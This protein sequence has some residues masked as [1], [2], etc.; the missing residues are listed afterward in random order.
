MFTHTICKVHS[1]AVFGHQRV[2]PGLGPFRHPATVELLQSTW[3]QQNRRTVNHTQPAALRREDPTGC[4][5]ARPPDSV[6]HNRPHQLTLAIRRWIHSVCQRG[7]RER[8]SHHASPWS[9][10]VNAPPPFASLQRRPKS[11]ALERGCRWTHLCC[12]NARLLTAASGIEQ[13]PAPVDSARWLVCRPR[14]VGH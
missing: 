10:A 1:L 11:S 12:R 9:Q 13:G 2:T 6:G 3:S 14:P 4:R 5:L 8:F 7:A